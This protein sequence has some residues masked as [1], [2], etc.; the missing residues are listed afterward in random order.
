[1]VLDDKRG[2]TSCKETTC[3]MYWL[4]ATW[5]FSFQNQTLKG[6]LQATIT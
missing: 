2:G 4:T 5:R 6:K 1:M 3:I